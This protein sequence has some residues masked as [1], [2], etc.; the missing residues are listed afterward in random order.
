MLGNKP[1][2]CLVD[3]WESILDYGIV[4]EYVTAFDTWGTSEKGEILKQI[5]DLRS[6]SDE[7]GLLDA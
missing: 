2:E 3:G 4:E 1:H 6:K 7:D 5:Y